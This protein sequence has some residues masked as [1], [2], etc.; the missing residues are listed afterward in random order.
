MFGI[1]PTEKGKTMRL[2][3]VD[4]FKEYMNIPEPDEDGNFTEAQ[5]TYLY[6]IVI[7][8]SELAMELDCAPTAAAVPIDEL[9]E[10]LAQTAMIDC[11]ACKEVMQKC[12][13]EEDEHGHCPNN[14]AAMWKAVITKWA[15]KK[16]FLDEAY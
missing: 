13:C 4:A 10:W 16:G 11:D 7:F 3:D 14:N 8:M 2:I 15:E 5:E 6:G 12:A 9:S 1:A